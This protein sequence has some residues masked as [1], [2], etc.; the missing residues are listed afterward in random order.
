MPIIKK[1]ILDAGFITACIRK[2]IDF[3]SQLK[4]MGLKIAVLRESLQEIKDI[5]SSPQ[6][7]RSDKDIIKKAMELFN[8]KSIDKKTIGKMRVENWLMNMGNEGYIIASKEPE[9]MRR[10][11]RKIIINKDNKLE[12]QE[13]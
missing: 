10:A 13:D 6:S 2:E 4:D 5:Q 8:D 9:V 11:N 12:L 7:S 3:I 1:V